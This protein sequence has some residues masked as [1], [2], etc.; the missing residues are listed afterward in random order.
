MIFALKLTLVLHSGLQ[1][2]MLF[3]FHMFHV[4]TDLFSLSLC[5]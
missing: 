4:H 3:I 1:S 2:V 5:V